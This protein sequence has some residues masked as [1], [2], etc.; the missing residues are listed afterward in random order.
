M[1]FFRGFWWNAIIGALGLAL[2]TTLFVGV[3][4]FGFRWSSFILAC[5][6]APMAISSLFAARNQW[7]R[8]HHG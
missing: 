1:R 3:S 7:K 8:S 6:G 5:L 4:F 2:S